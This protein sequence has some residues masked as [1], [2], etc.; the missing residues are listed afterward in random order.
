MPPSDFYD[1]LGV[2]R[3][4]SLEEI[5]KAYKKLAVKWHPDKNPDNQEEATEMFKAI[6]EAYETLSD[7]VKRRNYDLGGGQQFPDENEFQRSYSRSGNASHDYFHHAHHNFSHQ[8]AF[9]IFNQFFAEMDDFHGRMFDD[10]RQG[11]GGNRRNFG[12]MD[13]FFGSPFGGGFNGFG[14]S[15]MMGGGLFGGPDP[16]ADMHS[17]GGMGGASFSSFSSSSSNGFGGGTSRSV[18]TSTYIGPDGKKHTRKETTI[19]HA[20][21]RRESNVEEFV[22]D[23]QPARLKYQDDQRRALPI[24]SIDHQ[25]APLRRMASNSSTASVGSGQGVHRTHS[26]SSTA[27]TSTHNSYGSSKS[28]HIHK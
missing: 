4:A 23:S 18:S 26:V 1:V 8:R 7:P 27:S 11:Q 13:P 3:N 17:L 16:F 24:S 14:H 19:V 2:N 25:G 6:G 28:R 15:M 5:K 12:H 20:D 10:A 22:E 21:G 9:D